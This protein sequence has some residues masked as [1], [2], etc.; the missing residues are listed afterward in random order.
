MAKKNIA[1]IQLDN[2]DLGRVKFKNWPTESFDFD[3]K[4]H[5]VNPKA[6]RRRKNKSYIFYDTNRIEP[7]SVTYDEKETD[8]AKTMHGLDMS[9]TIRDFTNEPEPVNKWLVFMVLLFGSVIG[10]FAMVIAYP[11]IFG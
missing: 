5:T 7:L 10:A 4:K 3:G 6:I 2:G 1:L 9:K 8:K 11:H